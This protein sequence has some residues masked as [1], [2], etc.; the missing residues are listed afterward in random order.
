MLS[1]W[2][3]FEMVE[4]MPL[5]SLF[6]TSLFENLKFLKSPLSRE[7]DFRDDEVFLKI[8]MGMSRRGR[9][10]NRVGFPPLFLCMVALICIVFGYLLRY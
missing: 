8:E 10:S 3:A 5:R 7:T 2:Y 1:W 6:E 9:A 4:M